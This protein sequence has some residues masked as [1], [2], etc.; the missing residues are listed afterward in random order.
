M[1]R[2]LPSS[3]LENLPVATEVAEKVI[4]LPIYPALSNADVDRVSGLLRGF[5]H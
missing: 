2:S 4:C 3:R 1:Y 5:A